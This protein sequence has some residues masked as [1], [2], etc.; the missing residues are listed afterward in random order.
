[1]NH[2]VALYDF[3]KMS[4]NNLQKT[5]KVAFYCLNIQLKFRLEFRVLKLRLEK[6]L[7]KLQ[8]GRESVHLLLTFEVLLLFG[9]E[10]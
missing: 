6:P 2:G 9:F 10:L 4:R 1:M 7:H 3:L 5:G 8:L